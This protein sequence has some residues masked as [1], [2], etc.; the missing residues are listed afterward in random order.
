MRCSQAIAR[1]GNPRQ[2]REIARETLWGGLT[3]QQ[4]PVTMWA[5]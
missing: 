3:L 1:P 2:T 5:L 4:Q